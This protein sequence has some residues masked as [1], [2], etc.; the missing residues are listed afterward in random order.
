MLV[1]KLNNLQRFINEAKEIIALGCSVGLTSS[2]KFVVLHEN[3]IIVTT[4]TA[5]RN[6]GLY[7]VTRHKYDQTIGIEGEGIYKAITVVPTYRE[8]FVCQNSYCQASPPEA[9]KVAFLL[10]SFNE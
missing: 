8:D 2:E 6:P 5:W 3:W 9:I 10:W 7:H 1:N 4:S